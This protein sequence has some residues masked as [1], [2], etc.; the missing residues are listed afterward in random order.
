MLVQ[1][2]EASSGGFQEVPT[3]ACAGSGSRFR[4]VSESSG[5]RFGRVLEGAGGFQKVPDCWRRW[6]EGL[7]RFQKVPE[8]SGESRARRR[9][10]RV[11][12]AYEQN[13]VPM[14]RFEIEK[15]NAHDA[16]MY[17][18]LLLGIPPKLLVLK[19]A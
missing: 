18:L 17:A 14:C 16:A 11:L 13:N 6:Q 3:R 7:G 8:G 1:V 10:W 19:S 4:K 12:L 9:F 2:P 15:A 5:G